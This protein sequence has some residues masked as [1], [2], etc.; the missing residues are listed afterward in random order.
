[1]IKAFYVALLWPVLHNNYDLLVIMTERHFLDVSVIHHIVTMVSLVRRWY[2]LWL[3]TLIL[4]TCS[5]RKLDVTILQLFELM[6]FYSIKQNLQ[7]V[8]CLDTFLNIPDPDTNCH[9]IFPIVDSQTLD[10]VNV[11]WQLDELHLLI[12]EGA[13]GNVS[14]DRVHEDHVGELCLLVRLWWMMVFFYCKVFE[15]TT[16]FILIRFGLRAILIFENTN[17]IFKDVNMSSDLSLSEIIHILAVYVMV[18]LIFF[19]CIRLSG[20]A[21]E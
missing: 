20:K 16:L 6:R 5:L 10:R 21:A 12:L 3:Q 4:D 7:L 11:V 13:E 18:L 9:K 15:I 1:M 19:P 2:K 14:A 17:F 8:L